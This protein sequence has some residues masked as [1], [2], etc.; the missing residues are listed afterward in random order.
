MRRQ[1]ITHIGTTWGAI[2]PDSALDWLYSLPS[3]VAAEGIAGAFNSW[4]ATD[5]IG[6]RDWVD[7]NPPAPEMDQARLSLADVLSS[8]DVLSSMDLAFQ[9]SS[10]SGRDDAAARYFRLWR[11]TD[12]KSAQAWLA[13]NWNGLDAST[14]ERLALEQ[15]RTVVAR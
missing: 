7:Q 9:L 3:S 11:K 5:A 14:Q 6:L 15:S 4:A 2:E 10:P 8:S 1:V 12:D 13:Q